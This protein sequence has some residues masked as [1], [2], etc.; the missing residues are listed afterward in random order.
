MPYIYQSFV[1]RPNE[2]QVRKIYKI[3]EAK[4]FIYGECMDFID[5]HRRQGISL[6]YSKVVSKFYDLV[7]TRIDREIAIPKIYSSILHD[8]YKALESD[9]NVRKITKSKN[10]FIKLNTIPSF[11]KTHIFIENL[12]E[13]R[14]LNRPFPNG[15][16]TSAYIIEENGRIFK[17]WI[18]FKIPENFVAPN[19]EKSIGIDVGLCHYLNLSNGIKIDKPNFF[20][21]YKKKIN[22]MTKCLQK[23]RKNSANYKKLHDKLDNLYR[24]A[25]NKKYRFLHELSSRLARDYDLICMETLMTSEFTSFGGRKSEL[26]NDAS[27]LVF[28]KMLRYKCALN[29]KRFILAPKYFPSSQICNRCGYRDRRLKQISIKTYRCKQCKILLDRDLNAA[30]NLRKYGLGQIGMDPY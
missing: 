4:D 10:K 24:K 17:L 19:P 8:L 28:Q 23:K 21:M 13:I 29:C 27:I 14:W 26:W 1:I 22:K 9:K 6:D 25:H 11:S 12:G 5:C 20:E 15:E 7:Y 16:I 2:K 3:I 18:L 30:R